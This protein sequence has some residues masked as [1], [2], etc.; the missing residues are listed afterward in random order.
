MKDSA[1][2]GLVAVFLLFPRIA[3]SEGETASAD[4]GLDAFNAGDFALAHELWESDAYIGDPKA[5]FHLGYLYETGNGVAV[6]YGMAFFWYDKSAAASCRIAE[7]NLAN[8]Y[9]NGRGVAANHDEAIRLLARCVSS[10]GICREQIS[11]L[12]QFGE[13]RLTW[14]ADQG[15]ADAQYELAR[16]AQDSGDF[17]GAAEWLQ[18]A[19]QQQHGLAQV[20]LGDCYLRGEGVERDSERGETLLFRA[21][22][23]HRGDVD[24]IRSATSTIALAYQ[25]RHIT[26][27]KPEI[28]NYVWASLARA[29]NPE[30]GSFMGMMYDKIVTDAKQLMTVAELVEADKLVSQWSKLFAAGLPGVSEEQLRTLT[31]PP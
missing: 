8:L 4:P 21:M 18:R 22:V 27:S 6:D 9:M 30:T 20:A 12:R 2:G 13:E 23:R 3:T 11:A 19:A 14:Y 1:R 28:S 17:I 7:C 26:T 31:P 25:G 10:G 5:Q 29:D 24:V 16:Q 15:Y